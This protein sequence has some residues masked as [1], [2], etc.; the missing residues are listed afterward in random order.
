MAEMFFVQMP[1]NLLQNLLIVH[2]IVHHL[3]QVDFSIVKKTYLQIPISSNSHTITTA[4]KMVTHGTY[5]TYG[6]LVTIYSE[7]L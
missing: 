3:P 1:P 7:S 6:A 4:T 5:K 2:A